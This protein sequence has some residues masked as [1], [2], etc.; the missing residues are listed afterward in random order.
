MTFGL[1]GHKLSHSYSP[2]IHALLNDYSYELCELEEYEVEGFLKA[3]DFNGINVTIPYKKTVMPYLDESSSEAKR[4][5]SVNTI[6]KDKNNRLI[7]Y[8]TDYF[9]FKHMLLSNV[10]RVDDKKCLVLGNGGASLT[11]QCVLSDL[12]AKEITV[13]SRSG[14]NNYSNISNFYD[15]NVIINTTPV[16]MYPHCPEALIDITQFKNCCCVL[17]L[18]YNP[19]KT[20]ILLE[21]SKIGI[22]TSNGLLMLVA[23]A[24]VASEIFTSSTLDDSIIDEITNKLSTQMK[25]VTLIG[26]PG[27]GKSTV[28]NIIAQTLNRELIDTDALITQKINMPIPDYLNQYGEDAFRQVEHEVIFEV[29]KLSSKVIA[30]GG[31][32][33]LRE[34]NRLALCQNSIVVFINRDIDSLSTDGRP[35]SAGKGKLQELYN[36]RYPIYSTICDVKADS[37]ETP[38]LTAQSILK[39]IL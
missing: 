2:Q 4:I 15:Y 32:A 16:G 39:E 5:G 1:I 12:G 24:K 29:S 14:K 28:G 31:G 11:V 30:T 10:D 38:E 26:M 20:Q 19:A 23:Q 27:C 35:L 6:I 34:D 36:K 9:G 37:L 25:N 18:I 3:R 13:I 33:I 7:G 8:N 17:D 21:A 22:K